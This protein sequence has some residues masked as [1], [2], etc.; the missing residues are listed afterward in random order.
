MTEYVAVRQEES[1]EIRRGHLAVGHEA[2]IKI[3]ES[4]RFGL[5][6]WWSGS[7]LLVSY[8]IPQNQW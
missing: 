7:P 3:C 2:S 4:V 1:K 6:T 5:V 8:S